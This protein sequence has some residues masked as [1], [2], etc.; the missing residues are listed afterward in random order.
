MIKPWI[1]QIESPPGSLLQSRH[2]T[3]DQAIARAKQLSLG[4]NGCKVKVMFVWGSVEEN[5]WRKT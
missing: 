5:T 4:N 3:L 1:V 2:E